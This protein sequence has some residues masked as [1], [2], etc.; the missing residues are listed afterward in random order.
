MACRGRNGLIQ[1]GCT[2]PGK[3]LNMSVTPCVILIGDS[4]RKGYEADVREYLSGRATVWGAEENGGN[5][6]KVLE[7]IDTW[8]LEREA[9]VVHLNCGLHDLRREFGAERR[10]VEPEEYEANLRAILAHL[11]ENCSARIIWASTTP[12]NQVWHH[13]NKGFDRL[14]ADVDRYNAIAARVAANAG[15]PIDDLYSAVMQAGRDA[16][17]RQDGVHFTPAGSALLGT[18]VARRVESF[19][20]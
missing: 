16:V 20:S 5:S 9:A 13:A 18:T 6:R 3:E 8:A 1:R 14:E 11:Q 2:V 10:A 12:V 19:L 17:L 7:H 4:I 15:I